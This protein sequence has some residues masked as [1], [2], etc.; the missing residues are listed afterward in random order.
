MAK[1]HED[2]EVGANTKRMRLCPVTAC[3][4]MELRS[5]SDFEVKLSHIFGHIWLTLIWFVSYFQ[6]KLALPLNDKEEEQGGACLQAV[7]R[8]EGLFK[9]VPH[10][11]EARR[12]LRIFGRGRHRNQQ[13]G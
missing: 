11:L 8:G 7:P 6:Q 2:E 1:E 13:A 5:D 12:S 9:T 4:D 3:D 10:V